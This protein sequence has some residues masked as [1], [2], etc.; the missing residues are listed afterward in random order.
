MRIPKPH[1][2]RAFIL[3]SGILVV[4]ICCLP[5]FAAKTSLSQLDGHDW[6]TWEE[7]KKINFLSGFL[8]GSYYVIKQSEPPTPKDEIE[9]QYEE[10]RK[11][12]SSGYNGKKKRVQNSFS[13]EDVILWGHYRAA[14]IQKELID[15]AVFD[16][17][18]GHL[19]KGMDE[20]YSEPINKKIKLFDAVY[21]VKRQ[22]KGASR[23]E[24]ERT[25]FYLRGESAAP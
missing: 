1:G 12:L 6:Q 23:E 17:P 25:L 10:I 8:L 4:M 14:M 18:I 3:L 13:K 21:A 15:F 19:S 5:A 2:C 9:R 24:M 11:R 16:I 20:L 22:I 7:A